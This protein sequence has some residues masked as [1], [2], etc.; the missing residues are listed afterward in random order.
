MNDIPKINHPRFVEAS[1]AQLEIRK[2]E[3]Q[4]NNQKRKDRGDDD[5]AG[6]VWDE[7]AYVSVMALYNFLGALLASRLTPENPP[8]E[9]LNQN[10]QTSQQ[11]QA[12]GAYNRQHARGAGVDIKVGED[13]AT[14]AGAPAPDPSI[15]LANDVSEAD[16]KRIE[17]FQSDLLKLHDKGVAEIMLHR[18]T[19]FFDA[20]EQ[21]IKDAQLSKI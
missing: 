6:S 4:S 11:R 13:V 17:N 16:I 20:I 12:M 14:E 1:F 5:R 10:P 18:S 15:I 21:G 2:D 19:N 9:I 7:I 8:P 3:S